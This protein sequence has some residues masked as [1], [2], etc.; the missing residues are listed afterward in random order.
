MSDHTLNTYPITSKGFAVEISEM[1]NALA[2]V[3]HVAIVTRDTGSCF[4]S[5][6]FAQWVYFGANSISW[7]IPCVAYRTCTLIDDLFA[8]LII[9]T[10]RH[11]ETLPQRV[12]YI[13]RGATAHHIVSVAE[14]VHW[15]AFALLTYI[16]PS[17]AL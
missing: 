4:W 2:I 5:V 3:E 1:H 11:A 6:I 17:R 16:V 10:Y 14:G 12:G 9:G 15:N 7:V 8:E 13:A